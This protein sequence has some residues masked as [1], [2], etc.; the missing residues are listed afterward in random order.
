[1]SRS[2]CIV[3]A[4]VNDISYTVNQG[5]PILGPQTGT[6]PRPFRNQ[7]VQQEVSNWQASKASPVFAATPQC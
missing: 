4:L 1:M 7:A 6:G 2:K 3:R 5:C